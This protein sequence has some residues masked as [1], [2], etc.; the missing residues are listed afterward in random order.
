MIEFFFFSKTK[1]FV[2]KIISL[3]CWLYCLYKTMNRRPC[4]CTK[5]ILWELNSFHVFKLCFIP[6]DLQSCSPR[7][8]KRSIIY[9]TVTAGNKAG[10]D[11]VLIQ[12]V[13]LCYLNNILFMLS[14][15]HNFHKKRK[16]VCIKTRSTTASH[17]FKG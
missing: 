6:S 10:V 7:D 4:L 1:W 11:L 15:K 17:S 9:F 3:S 12:P 14:F 2:S 16:E 8:W 5:K 13:L